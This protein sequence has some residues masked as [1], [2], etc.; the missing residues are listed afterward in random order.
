VT[1]GAADASIVYVT[2]V[3]ATSRVDI[4]DAQNVIA[5][6]PI[7]L[8]KASSNREAALAFIKAIVSGSGQ[9]A[10]EKAGFITG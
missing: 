3:A 7:A 8:V 2:D 10:L 1:S 4:P 6:Y 9:G 5:E